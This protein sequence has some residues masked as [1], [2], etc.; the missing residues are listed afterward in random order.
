MAEEL[1]KMADRFQN[2]MLFK[3][4][5]KSV[6]ID[7]CDVAFESLQRLEENDIKGLFIKLPSCQ[8]KVSKAFHA[9]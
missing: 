9:P 6:G 2:E 7:G 1:K 4:L 3:E 5:V 8:G